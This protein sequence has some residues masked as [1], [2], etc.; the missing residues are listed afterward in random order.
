ML[1]LKLMPLMSQVYS[2]LLQA[3]LL[4][5][6]LLAAGSTQL[7][8]RV[9][10]GAFREDFR[11]SSSLADG[12]QYLWNSPVGW[13]VGSTGDLDTGSIATRASYRPLISNGEFWTADG[14]FTGG[15]N[16]PSGFIRI[17]DTGGH[18]GK[19]AAVAGERDRYA[20]VAYTVDADGL[21][22]IENSYVDMVTESGDGVE[23]LVF[24]GVSEAI[25]QRTVTQV[26]GTDFDL[27][28]GFL[29][30]GQTIYIAAGPRGDASFDSFQYDFEI[31][32][33]PR[34]SIRAQ[35]E[36]ALNAGA[37]SVII[38]PGRYYY[39]GPG[40]HVNLSG[41]DLDN[42]FEI[43]AD[44][45]TLICQTPNRALE[46]NQCRGL[47]IQ[48]LTIDYDPVLYRQGTIV[49]HGE[50]S[51]DLR[52]HEGYPENLT[53]E[54]TSGIAYDTL[55]LDM[56]AGTQTI[57]PNAVTELSPGLY[58]VT[59]PQMELP[60]PV[61][62]YLSFTEP[63]GVPHAIYMQSCEEMELV[64]IE[65]RGSPAFAFLSRE[66]RAIRLENMRVLPGPTPI[67]GTIPRLLSSN[68]DGIHFKSSIGDLTISNC[69]LSYIGDDGIVLTGAYDPVIGQ[70]SSDRIILAPKA[71]TVY[72]IGESL[73]F[74]DPAT[75]QIESAVVESVTSLSMDRTAIV[76]LVESYF[77][78]AIVSSSNFAQ[79][80]ELQLDRV[81][82]ASVGVLASRPDF[83]HF[84]FQIIGCE[85][86]NSR[87]RG[88]QV[89]GNQGVISGNTIRNTFL[90]GIQARPDAKFWLEGDFSESLRIE[91]NVLI[92]CGIGS[93]N[94]VAS[95][96]V[97]SRGF[98]NLDPSN[99]HRDVSI[100][101]NQVSNAPGCSLF[102]G[103]SSGV[104]IRSNHFV[105]SH[106]DI[107]DPQPWSSSVVWLEY[108]DDIHVH[109]L[110][111]AMSP[112]EDNIDLESLLGV[113]EEVSNLQSPAI[114]FLDT[115]GDGLTDIWESGYSDSVTGLDAGA[116]YDSDGLTVREEFMANLDPYQVD[117]F[118]LKID[119]SGLLSWDPIPHRF[120]TL[121]TSSSPSLDFDVIALDLAGSTNSFLVDLEEAL[122][123]AF[124]RLSVHD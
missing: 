49:A 28:I 100:I 74:S 2:P 46:F 26:S 71:P 47:S 81:F 4:L 94:A 108:V 66:G 63:A 11:S 42:G 118:E 89:K 17:S 59:S 60:L 51:V 97:G 58:R 80:Y 22:A 83:A 40:R 124:Y 117:A 54:A 34:E 31:V 87:A 119:R 95:I 103:N 90:A 64:D 82:P 10:V 77:P 61:G 112:E 105:E 5:L 123:S 23:L 114:L 98:D 56:L 116:D 19:S 78:S 122:S 39:N 93:R 53:T 75:G 79:A 1:R 99:G 16:D 101:R 121:R 3:S 24:P 6:S 44:G 9:V 52:L 13:A 107:W 55:T 104:Q 106:Q 8:A 7:D 35:I 84:G 15:N 115:D 45:V 18:A 111:L 113:G 69:R 102:V 67:R 33:Y 70:P 88:I 12:W 38:E 37:D 91:A 109:G 32:R 68:A 86:D 85:V 62:A 120:F 72:S 30:A 14:D 76:E 20:I 96:Y 73:K 50:Q 92:D 43:L 57:Y 65:I 48:G 27:E 25:L 36:N 110:N 29:S 21:Y 41:L